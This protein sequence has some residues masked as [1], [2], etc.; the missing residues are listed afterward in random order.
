MD[1]KAAKASCSIPERC[2]GI[3]CGSPLRP[4]EDGYDLLEQGIISYHTCTARLGVDPPGLQDS[5]SQE[6]TFVKDCAAHAW[7]TSHTNAAHSLETDTHG[8]SQ[9]AEI[10]YVRQMDSYLAEFAAG[11]DAVR[12]I[13]ESRARCNELGARCSGI[14]CDDASERLC[15]VREGPDVMVSP[16]GEVSYR[17]SLRYTPDERLP[18][19]LSDAQGPESCAGEDQCSGFHRKLPAGLTVRAGEVGAHFRSYTGSQAIV[20]RDRLRLIPKSWYAEFAADGAFCSNY[21]GLF[22]AIWHAMF[23]EP[24]AQWPRETDPSLPLY[25]KWGIPTMYSFGDEGVI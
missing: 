5:P 23:G 9:A 17:K 8:Q 13:E 7:A 12:S 18:Q 25:L 4:G 14:T 1:R 11:D 3:T 6:I 15:T 19:F 10:S 22:E 16:V 24:L 2:A 20:R 21:T